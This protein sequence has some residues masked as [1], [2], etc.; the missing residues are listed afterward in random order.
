MAWKVCDVRR[1]RDPGK[2]IGSID[3]EFGTWVHFVVY[4]C[5]S[6]I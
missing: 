4:I 1:P 3:I 6:G 2:S 5:T